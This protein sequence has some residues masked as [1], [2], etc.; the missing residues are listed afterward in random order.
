[1]PLNIVVKCNV[2]IVARVL[3]NNR[4]LLHVCPLAT[5]KMFDINLTY[6]R[7]STT[8]VRAFDGV[9]REINGEIDLDVEICP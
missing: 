4:S 9:R 6:I 8:M 7:P 5:L 1:M 2:K 3:I